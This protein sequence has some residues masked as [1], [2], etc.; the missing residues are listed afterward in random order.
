MAQL[1]IVG[2]S[3]RKGG[4]VGELRYGKG[5][6]VWAKCLGRFDSL[7][8]WRLDFLVVCLRP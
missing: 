7:A 5:K 2:G 8:F 3:A 6:V 1:I 4:L